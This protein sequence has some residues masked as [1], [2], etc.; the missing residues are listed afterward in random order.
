MSRD[1]IHSVVEFEIQGKQRG[2]RNDNYALL[3]ASRKDGCLMSEILNRVNENDS[4]AFMHLMYGLAVSYHEFYSRTVDFRVNDMDEW[5][6]ELGPDKVRELFISLFRKPEQP[7]NS[8]SPK[9][10]GIPVV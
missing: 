9:E 3:V 1:K 6:S 8:E 2:F 4:L 7:K 5:I 10:T